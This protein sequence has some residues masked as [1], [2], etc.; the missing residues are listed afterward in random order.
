MP[1]SK[2][3]MAQNG[4]GQDELIIAF[5]KLE[6]LVERQK[7]AL[8]GHLVTIGEKMAYIEELEQRA[9]GDE[10]KDACRSFMELQMIQAEN[11]MND[12][13][14]NFKGAPVDVVRG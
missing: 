1:I 12:H 3:I 13:F 11:F 2:E 6:D 8:N 9:S 7:I 4:W 5:N 10:F 14:V